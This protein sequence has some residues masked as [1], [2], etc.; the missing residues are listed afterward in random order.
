MSSGPSRTPDARTCA[1]STPAPPRR[2]APAG[3]G[4]RPGPPTTP[5]TRSRSAP[6]RVG[7]RDAAPSPAGRRAAGRAAPA[8]HSAAGWSCSPTAHA[9]HAAADVSWPACWSPAST[10]SA[11]DAP[12]APATSGC[13]PSRRPAPGTSPTPAPPNPPGPARCRRRARSRPPPPAPHTYGPSSHPPRGW[14]RSPPWAGPHASAARSP[15][16]R[17]PE[18]FSSPSDRPRVDNLRPRAV[19][20]ADSGPTTSAPRTPTAAP[21][22]TATR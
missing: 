20:T 3:S 14:Q 12:P 6:P 5:D 7:P 1:A 10:R 19:P 13:A 18:T 2:R 11:P 22:W 4:P 15:P 21:S 8:T 16:R 17:S 9:H